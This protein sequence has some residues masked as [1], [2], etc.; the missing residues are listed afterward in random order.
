MTQITLTLNLTPANLALLN[1]VL[2]R[3]TN[4]ETAGKALV[5]N[6][7][8]ND[9]TPAPAPNEPQNDPTPAPAPKAKKP[10]PPAPDVPQNV[11]EEPVSTPVSKTD[12]RALALKLSKAG[13]QN[14]LKAIFQKYGADKLSA[15]A[16]ADYPALLQDLEAANG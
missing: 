10:K 12:V 7:P 13:K 11:A 1:E 4:A 3:L 14:E 2:P 16:E 9:P 6:E 8:Q 15:I 5:P